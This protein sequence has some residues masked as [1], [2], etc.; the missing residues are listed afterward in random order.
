[1]A[2]YLKK[3]IPKPEEDLTAV[4]DTVREIL[5]RIK[6]EGEVAVRHYSKTFDQW[7]PKY[8]K[9]SEDQIR[10]VKKQLPVSEVED[11]DF[12]QAQIRNFAQEQMKRIVGFEAETFPGV[13]LGQKIIPVASSGAYVPGG[14]Y[15]MLASAHMTVITP[16]VAGVPR[17]VSC[18]PP[19]K[20]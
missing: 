8:F 6:A 11:I 10:A 17:V 16:K 14:R 13:H 18:S 19:V 7:D 20:G 3:A 5:A 12:C 4:R 1:M 9:I 15:P 2:E